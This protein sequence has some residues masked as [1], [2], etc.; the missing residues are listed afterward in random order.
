MWPVEKEV[1]TLWRSSRNDGEIIALV[2]RLQRRTPV[3][4]PVQQRGGYVRVMEH[5]LG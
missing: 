2:H 4:F 1:M 5:Y 3:L